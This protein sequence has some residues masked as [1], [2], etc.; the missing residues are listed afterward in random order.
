[1]SNRKMEKN[2]DSSFINPT[3]EYMSDKP[4]PPVGGA[5]FRSNKDARSPQDDGMLDFVPYD[6]AR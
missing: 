4:K 1:M 3:S 5:L 6:R 2:Q